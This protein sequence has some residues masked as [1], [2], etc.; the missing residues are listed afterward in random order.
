VEHDLI[1]ARVGQGRGDI[2]K[3]HASI[4]KQRARRCTFHA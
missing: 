3:G 1:E 2:G 4:M